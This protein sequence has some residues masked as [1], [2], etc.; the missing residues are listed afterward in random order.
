MEEIIVVTNAVREEL[1]G[2]RIGA[3]DYGKKRI[4]FAVAD[5]LHI[6][7]TPRGFFINDSEVLQEILRAVERER[8]GSVIV[9]M[10][11]QHDNTETPM[12]QEISAFI[13]QLRTKIS[14]PI[15]VVDE[16][17]SSREAQKMMISSGK[18][19]SHRAQKGN[20]DEVAAAIILRDFLRELE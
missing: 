16:A 2:K 12:M 6:L 11:V 19:K 4:G 20:A 1:R 15:Y 7:A 13:G 3:L 9:G 18:K 8:L 5:E 17:Y 14:L 10:P